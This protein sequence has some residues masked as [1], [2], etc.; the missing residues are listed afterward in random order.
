MGSFP[1]LIRSRGTA[2]GTYAPPPASRATL[3]ASPNQA[4]C[5][6]RAAASKQLF[7]FGVFALRKEQPA[8]A[9]A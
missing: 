1:R 6:V 4:P 5:Q 8:G 3:P 2:T 9:G 7:G